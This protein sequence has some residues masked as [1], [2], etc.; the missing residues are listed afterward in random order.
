MIV[1]RV[2][3]MSLGKVLGIIYAV[4]GFIV[5]FFFS[6]IMALGAVLGTTLDESP[7]VIAFFWGI[8]SVFAFPVLYGILGFIGGIV[9]AGIYNV[10]SNWVGGIEIEL[11]EKPAA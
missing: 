6:L 3:P 8:G 11:E 1:K 9:T 7:G 2:G 5:G 4:F 10:I